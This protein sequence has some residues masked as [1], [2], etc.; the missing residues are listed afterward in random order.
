MATHPLKRLRHAARVFVAGVED[1][2]V[3][4][5]LGFIPTPTV[6]EAIAQAEKFHGRDCSIVCV[7]IL[8]L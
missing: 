7:K 2:A 8:G 4:Q 1:P 5:H 3:P 6:E